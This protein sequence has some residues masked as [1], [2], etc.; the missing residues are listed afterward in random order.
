MPQLAGFSYDEI[1]L[2]ATRGG[3]R[4][5]RSLAAIEVAPPLWPAVRG[6]DVTFFFADGESEALSSGSD[7]AGREKVE[8]LQALLRTAL[9]AAPA[10]V[11]VSPLVR[12]LTGDPA[13]L[14]PLRR[15]LD[16]AR[17]RRNA[18]AAWQA[19]ALWR[20]QRPEEAESTALAL[21]IAEETGKRSNELRE[22]WEAELRRAMR[23]PVVLEKLA[24][25]YLATDHEMAEPY[26][27]LV[28]K[29]APK[30]PAIVRA[31]A[32]WLV[33]HERIAEAEET[34]AAFMKDA[35]AG[36][37]EIWGFAADR[38]ALVRYQQ[39]TRER[40]RAHGRRRLYWAGGS[41]VA[42]AAVAAVVFFLW[43][44]RSLRNERTRQLV[45]DAVERTRRA[46]ALWQPGTGAER[47]RFAELK[48]KAEA[49]DVPAMA[50]LSRHYRIGRTTP[51][52]AALE[53]RWLER[54]AEA[55]HVEA[56]VTLAGFLFYGRGGTPVDARKAFEWY[57]RAA[58]QGNGEARR[59]VITALRRGAG[60]TRDLA[61]AKQLTEELAAAGDAWAATQL[62]LAR[63]D[64]LKGEAERGNPYAWGELGRRY[65]F[66]LGANKDAAEAL[67]CYE[68]AVKGGHVD[69][70]PSLARFLQSGT[71]VPRDEP[72]AEALL[73]EAAATDVTFAQTSLAGLLSASKRGAA[74]MREARYW[75]ERAVHENHRFAMYSTAM[76]YLRSSNPTPQEVDRGRKLL[77]MGGNAGE[78]LA[79]NEL[80]RRLRD[81]RFG[82]KEGAA[83]LR[84]WHKSADANNTSAMLE[85]ATVYQQGDPAAGIYQ[86]LGE[87]R[88]FLEKAA[89]LNS[90]EA[91]KRL[92]AFPSARVTPPRKKYEPPADLLENLPPEGV[93]KLVFHIRPIYPFE[94]RRQGVSG[95]VI[96]DFLVAKDGSVQNAYVVKA[97]R[98]EFAA[99]A[100]AA[101]S[102]WHFRPGTKNGQP[103][104]TH[105]QVPV[106][107][108]LAE[109]PRPSALP[110]V[111]QVIKK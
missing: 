95:E 54:A 62:A 10:G 15:D 103:V 17:G 24:R 12:A 26:A 94:M 85:L 79:M 43:F 70:V 51:F 57:Q 4:A 42:A 81:G 63:I 110:P 72:R 89:K 104:P 31:L 18:R 8:S 71:V 74:G 98:P 69:S 59:Q 27:R 102:E 65:D 6:W 82:G 107:F 14:P 66:G 48:P 45:L 76:L 3:V 50:E 9:A 41:L 46:N 39:H 109:E 53:R 28:L 96:V 101:V 92:A 88:R 16:A 68:N 21:A 7:V 20:S 60:I 37:P 106:I 36:G 56:Q 83:A 64:D 1:G 84:W 75:G 30:S 2:H 5:W 49:G 52:D 44:E 33:R 32:R 55:G 93:P 67:R 23:D 73:R 35:P 80:A 61:R 13:A 78:T 22:A 34:M 87:A 40:W 105:M 19:W 58:D 100:V 86:D 47:Q 91:K 97:S 108:S 90:E 25:L 38:L 111:E 11:V 29:A 99:N 77:E